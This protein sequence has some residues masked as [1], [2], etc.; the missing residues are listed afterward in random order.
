MTSSAPALHWLRL[1]GLARI[2]LD[3]AA[4][5]GVHAMGVQRLSAFRFLL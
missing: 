2:A 3:T 5:Y 1:P 4:T